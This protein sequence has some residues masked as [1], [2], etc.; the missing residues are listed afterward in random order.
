MG[1]MNRT[2]NQ[3]QEVGNGEARKGNEEEQEAEWESGLWSH[4]LPVQ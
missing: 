1:K 3:G 4:I 2:V